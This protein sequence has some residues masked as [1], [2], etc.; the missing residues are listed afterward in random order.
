MIGIISMIIVTINLI[1]II[2]MNKEYNELKEQYNEE[3]W[4]RAFKEEEYINCIK[5]ILLTLQTEDNKPE[6][7]ICKSVM[8]NKVNDFDAIVTNDS[9]NNTQTIKLEPKFIVM[10]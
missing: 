1:T 7:T 2:M 4:S 9:F 8:K 10:K 5:A 6:I 3:K